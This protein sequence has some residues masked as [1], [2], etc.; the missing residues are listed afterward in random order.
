MFSS[1]ILIILLLGFVPLWGQQTP[2]TDLC[3]T[4]LL[5]HLPV[6]SR[7]VVVG[8][9]QI[10]EAPNSMTS[11]GTIQ[12][13]EIVSILNEPVCNEFQDV[14]HISNG[15]LNGWVYYGSFGLVPDFE[16]FGVHTEHDS[17][18]KFGMSHV[19]Y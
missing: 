16:A 18:L 11:I 2:A 5:E 9:M 6:G 4:N 13:G 19:Y 7:A 3:P 1:L 15:L 17:S 12:A 8:S 10:F 14:W